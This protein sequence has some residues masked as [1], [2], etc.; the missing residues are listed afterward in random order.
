LRLEKIFE[1]VKIGT[2]NLMN[3][4]VMAP[5]FSQFASSEG[6][7]TSRMID[8]YEK[9]AQSGVG[10]LMV[11][12]TCIDYPLGTFT[13]ELRI[14]E[15][16]FIVRL[17]ELVNII[18]SYNVK[19]SI[20]L[21]HAGRQ[22]YM[23]ATGGLQPVSASEVPSGTP[24]L[25]SKALSVEEIRTIIKKFAEGAER[26]KQAE[27]DAIEIHGAH[28]Y[29]IG[30]FLSPFTNKRT[31]EYGGDLNNR[32]RFPLEI[33]EAVRERVGEEYP[34]IY[35]ISGHEYIE[36]G[37]TIDDTKLVAKK[38][39]DNGIDAIHVSAGL[40]E[41]GYW[42]EQPMYL[43]RGCLVDL[44]EKIKKEVE[45]PVIAVGRIND[46]QL[47]ERI[48]REDKADLIAMGRAFLADP[49]FL[50]KATA[51]RFA[52]IRKCIACVDGCVENLFRRKAITCT[53]NPEVGMEGRYK[54]KPADQKKK[55]VIVGG[56]PA[57]MQASLICK[58]R[59]HEVVLYEE[60]E[61]LGGQLIIASIPPDKRE[62]K[63]IT[64]WLINQVKKQGITLKLNDKATVDSILEENPD[65]IILATGA[66]PLIPEIPGIE[67]DLVLT[68]DEVLSNINILTSNKIVVVGA[69]M[70]GCETADYI[71]GKNKRVTL[72]AR[73]RCAHD[74]PTRI[75]PILFKRL[76]EK[77]VELIKGWGLSEI[78]ESSAVF[79]NIHNND[80]KELDADQIV[81]AAGYT[82]NKELAIE[83]ER[84]FK[85]AYMIG[86]C[87][88]PRKLLNAI[89][90]GYRVALNI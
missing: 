59:G 69:G 3:R 71:A 42:Y 72:V 75:K 70:I 26:A 48:L 65:A 8:Y 25:K 12:V 20:Q 81:I 51:G 38:L 22:T 76:E 46:I 79:I 83:L 13:R 55:I 53:I 9:R 1:P 73:K 90:E 64:D 49:L 24:G 45:I 31:D 2:L 58:L 74:V 50:K 10:L 66:K 57:G 89:H 15:D 37:L 56:G 28:G 47:A 6:E 39:E 78:K 88:A 40:R 29:L 34:V 27:F 41:T 5:M 7:V 4:I 33:V 60:K 67:R 62:I 85:K 36:G 86:D 14:D 63:E 61:E 87:V 43:P 80:K 68:A 44:A 32:M 17:H 19:T 16:M 18:H 54:I 82:A 84:K 52:D 30:Q 23:G 77:G 11:E 35:R 21:H